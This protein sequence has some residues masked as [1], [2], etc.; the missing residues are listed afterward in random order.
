MAVILMCGPSGAGKSTFARD[1]EAAGWTRMSF[2][3]E[4]W[5][6]GVRSLPAPRELMHDIQA[7]LVARLEDL[8]PRG[9]DV[10][11]DL[12]SATRELRDDYRI[13]LR[14]LG[15]VA[16]TVYLPVD[17]A[18]AL[19]RVR[20]RGDT[21][22]DDYRVADDAVVLHVDEFEEPTFDEYP[23]RVVD[24]EL[25]VRHARLDEAADLLAFW[26]QAAENDARPVD[27]IEAV[28]RLLERD[29]A[30]VLVAEAQGRVAGTIIAGWDGWRAHLYRLAVA[31]EGRGRGIGRTL[32]GHAERRLVALGA[33]RLDAMVLDAN[34][35]GA[36]MW[37]SAGYVPQGEW[38][39]WVKPV[40]GWN[41]SPPR[42]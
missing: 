19:D 14:R 21:G 16:E 28:Q 11:I 36:A 26:A 10:V 34:D 5:R 23:L 35:T 3:V 1:L 8:V 17:A 15:A 38:S 18:A 22:P 42:G 24:G 6:A 39:R 33:T 4:T 37:R 13:L 25:T 31:P 12:P 20:E 27:S 30:A 32:L 29:P 2:D 7:E 40:E 9:V 41:V